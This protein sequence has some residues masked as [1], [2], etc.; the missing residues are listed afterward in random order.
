MLSL[1]NFL[2]AIFTLVLSS[3]TSYSQTPT[4]VVVDSGS[5]DQSETSIAVAP[6]NSSVLMATW[7]DFSNGS[8]PQPGYA[9]STDGG[10]TT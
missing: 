6:N 4:N 10:G 7:N 9:F 5:E 2:L 8:Y 1:K 3:T